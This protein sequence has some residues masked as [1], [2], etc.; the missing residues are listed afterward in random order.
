[1]ANI[2]FMVIWRDG[3]E[4]ERDETVVEFRKIE[5]GE[6]LGGRVLYDGCEESW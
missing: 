1:M 3:W 2:P 4:T 6:N 5:R